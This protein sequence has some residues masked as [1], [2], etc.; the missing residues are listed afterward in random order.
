[1]NA[2]TALETA[3][4]PVSDEP[5]LAKAFSRTNQGAVVRRPGDGPGARVVERKIPEGLAYQA[6]DD[7]DD[8][9][10]GEQVG[11]HRERPA[12]LA[13]AAQV[14][15]AHQQDDDDGHQGQLVLADVLH[16]ADRQRRGDGRG[17]GRDL[18]RDGDDVVDHQGDGRDLGDPGSEII[19]GDHVRSAGPGVD[20]HHL[21]VGQN[22]QD[23]HEKHHA[24]D[25][26]DQG[27][28]CGGEAAFEQLDQD[29]LGAVG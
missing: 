19:P 12:C 15:E 20:R 10:G 28:R 7:H 17:P 27:E 4:M 2:L 21:A 9:H 6:S 18:H 22:H 26:Q 24:G 8:D 16:D 23:H 29:L 3:S 14:A 1:L 25:R 13:D 5:P 11:R